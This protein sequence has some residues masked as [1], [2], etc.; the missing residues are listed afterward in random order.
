[1]FCH[2]LLANAKTFSVTAFG[3]LGHVPSNCVFPALIFKD[4]VFADSHDT[5][6]KV[7]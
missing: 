3:M 4:R 1:M 6:V 7:A 2:E 5:A